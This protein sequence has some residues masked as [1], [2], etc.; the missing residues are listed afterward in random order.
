MYLGR[1]VGTV[2]ATA[3]NE[4]LSGKTLFIVQPVTPEGQPTGKTLVCSDFVGAG[5]GS[6]IYYCRGREASLPF[7]PEEVPSDATIIAIVDELRIDREAK[8]R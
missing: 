2:W 5:P 3:K 6:L 7:A 4:G 1:V 8:G